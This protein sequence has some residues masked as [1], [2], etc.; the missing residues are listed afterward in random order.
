M[1][2]LKKYRFL[3]GAIILVS[4]G[5]TSAKSATM[6]KVDRDL[7]PK[8]DQALIVFMRHSRLGYAISSSL[9]DVTTDENKFLGVFKA[10][11][12]VGYDVTP[13]EYTFMV[14]SESADFLKATV[15]AGKTYYVVVAPRMGWNKARFSFQPLRQADLMGS[16]FAT[17]NQKTYFVENTPETEEWARNNAP[18]I[19]DKRVR[20]WA[21]W[22]EKTQ[23]E[24]DSQTLNPEDGI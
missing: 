6:M 22:S 19:S 21:K 13:G 9:F 11:V 3:L 18:D 24:Q 16:E 10:G 23:E 15:S 7:T 5:L 8:P 1:K 20:Y 17:W 2:N 14:V 4:F 12:K